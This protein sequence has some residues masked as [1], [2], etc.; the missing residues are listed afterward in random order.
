VAVV[1]DLAW[2]DASPGDGTTLGEIFCLTFIRGVDGAEALRR[3]GGLPDTTATRGRSDVEDLHN[4][5]DGYPEVALALELGAWT[6]VFE[7]NGFNGSHLAT[8]V[9]R[10]TEAVSVLRHDYASPAFVYA[11]NSELITQFDPTFPTHR[12]GA[13]PD[14]LLS[15]M[16]EFGFATTDDEEN[17]DDFGSDIGRSL[18]L[19]EQ[20]TGVLPTFEALTGPLTSA[21][22]EPWFSEA[23]KPPAGRPGHDGPVDAITEVRRLTN[24]HGLTGTPGL[25]DALTAAEHGKPVT[26]TPDSPLG[27]HVRAWLTESRRA[28]WS[29]NDHSGRHRMTEAERNRAYGLGWLARALGA[30][31][32][33]ATATPPS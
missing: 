19:V 20:L 12:Y 27:R 16:H 17:E 2:A 29:L 33:P 28:G 30:A 13:D 11:V 14:R 15:G 10:G 31:L 32:Q 23:R 3:M 7:P 21:H 8:A 26:V 5:D 9:S 25:A 18:R 6:V 24:L 4:F 1:D 22:I